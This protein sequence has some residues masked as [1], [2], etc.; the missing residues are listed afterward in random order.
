MVRTE[1]IVTQLVFE[2]SLRIRVKAETSSESS[3]SGSTTAVGTPETAS[4]AES[5]A[6]TEQSEATATAAPAANGAEPQSPAD[7]KDKKGKKAQTLTA[8]GVKPESKS[9]TGNLT[10]KLNNLVTTD[11]QNVTYG[12]DFM[13]ICTL[14]AYFTSSNL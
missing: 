12:R 9:S 3:S 8:E 14:P 5:T 1:A 11:L 4:L 2:H 6:N 7:G 10:G 13:L